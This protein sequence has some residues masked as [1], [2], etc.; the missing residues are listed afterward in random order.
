M[1]NEAK[2]KHLS[3]SMKRE[4]T[5]DREDKAFQDRLKRCVSKSEYKRVAQMKKGKHAKS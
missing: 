1:K 2:A 3:D 5:P 4:N